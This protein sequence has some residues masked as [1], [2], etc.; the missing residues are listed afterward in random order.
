MTFEI[1]EN[2]LKSSINC[3]NAYFTLNRNIPSQYSSQ[4][5]VIKAH[6]L[7]NNCY[8]LS[9]IYYLL[10]KGMRSN[11]NRLIFFPGIGNRM[12]LV[13]YL[14]GQQEVLNSGPHQSEFL[15]LFTIKSIVIITASALNS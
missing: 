1:R 10:L 9:N 15:R 12:E 8:L 5:L 13:F 11:P 7:F 6:D 4:E 2:A 14:F 3:K